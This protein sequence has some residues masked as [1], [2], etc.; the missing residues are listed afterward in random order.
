MNRA[1]LQWPEERLLGGV[2]K[3]IYAGTKWHNTNT[4]NKN[5]NNKNTNNKNNP[6]ILVIL[7]PI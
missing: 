6:F 3:T 5:I 4:N 7:L 2:L 1:D